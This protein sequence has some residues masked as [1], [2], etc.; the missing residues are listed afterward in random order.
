M[1]TVLSIFSCCYAILEKRIN[2]EHYCVGMRE[3]NIIE[4]YPIVQFKS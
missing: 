4:I 1:N 3:L 2:L